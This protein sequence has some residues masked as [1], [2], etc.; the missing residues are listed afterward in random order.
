MHLSFSVYVKEPRT[1]ETRYVLHSYSELMFCCSV[2]ILDFQ[3]D[4][5]AHAST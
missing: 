4:V 3:V 5:E 1:G 2:K